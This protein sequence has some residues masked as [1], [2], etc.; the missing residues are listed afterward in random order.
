[1][2]TPLHKITTQRQR[3]KTRTSLFVGVAVSLSKNVNKHQHTSLEHDT[4][5]MYNLYTM[6][7][8]N[9]RT[10]IFKKPR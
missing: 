5:V 2:A 9:D 6:I 10:S 8:R 4:V 1:M 3:V 7:I